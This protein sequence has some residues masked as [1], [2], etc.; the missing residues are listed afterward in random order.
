MTKAIYKYR[1]GQY[2]LWQKTT[3]NWDNME[4]ETRQYKTCIQ[5]RMISEFGAVL[6]QGHDGFWFDE[7]RIV[8]ELTPEERVS[9]Y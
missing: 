5:K 1:L 9:V 3:R 8:R 2:V 6:Y 4:N 7:V